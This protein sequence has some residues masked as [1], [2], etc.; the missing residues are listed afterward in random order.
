MGMV[1]EPT[2]A[3]GSTILDFLPQIQEALDIGG[4]THT[5]EDVA[6]ELLDGKAQLWIHGEGMVI[7][8]VEDWPQ[9]RILRFWLAA[10]KLDDILVMGDYIYQWG[11][12]QGC[13]EAGITGRRGWV[14]P[15]ATQ[16]WKEFKPRVVTFTKEL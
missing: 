10:G 4:N 7:T 2:P 8:T 12:E 1:L 13:T 5:V 15:L 9:K 16:G 3:P 14:K 11:R 6:Q